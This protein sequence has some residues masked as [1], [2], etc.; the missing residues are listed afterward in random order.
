MGW[1][2]YRCF[3]IRRRWALRVI[4]VRVRPG[5]KFEVGVRV[6]V[7]AH[8][9]RGRALTRARYGCTAVRNP[10]LD[11]GLGPDLGPR[12]LGGAFVAAGI[13]GLLGERLGGGRGVDFSGDG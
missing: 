12:L 5:V 11:P 9:L 3:G 4:R 1:M 2:C 6:I 7:R 8:R 10:G 13:N